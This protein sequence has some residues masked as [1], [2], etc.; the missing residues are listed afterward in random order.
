LR[1]MV[2]GLVIHVWETSRSLHQKKKEDGEGL[3]IDYALK[4]GRYVGTQ[5]S[6]QSLQISIIQ[7][8]SRTILEVYELNGFNFLFM[9]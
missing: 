1:R 5:T 7:L 8:P 3:L 9:H 6:A 4:K 2:I